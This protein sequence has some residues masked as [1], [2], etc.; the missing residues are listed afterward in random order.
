MISIQANEKKSLDLDPQRFFDYQ[1]C[2]SERGEMD[3]CERK[4]LNLSTMRMTY[5]AR[6]QLRDIMLMS[7]FPEECLLSK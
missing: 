1:N 3:Y 5:E 6:N 2:N 7:G 4:C